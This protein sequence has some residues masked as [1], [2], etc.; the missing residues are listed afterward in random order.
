VTATS[1]L[2]AHFWHYYFFPPG[3]PWWKGAVWGNV[4]AIAPSAPVLIAGGMAAYYFHKRAMAPLHAKI[5]QLA[6]DHQARHEEHVELMKSLLDAMDPETDGGLADL[7]DRLDPETPGGIGV[8]RER[9][10]QLAHPNP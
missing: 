3:E 8:L 5:N 9:L 6:R 4:I 7:K 10:D 2:F 1:T